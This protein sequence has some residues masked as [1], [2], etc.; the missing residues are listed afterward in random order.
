MKMKMKTNTLRLRLQITV[1]LFSMAAV[2]LVAC[3]KNEVEG[4]DETV[5]MT[6]ITVTP[7]SVDVRVGDI[8]QLTV[9]PVPADATGRP[10]EWVSS[11]PDVATV[12]ESGL[13]AALM[14][15]SATVTVRSGSLSRRIP[16]T[17][18]GIARMKIGEITCDVTTSETEELSSGVK[19]YKLSLPEFEN[20]VTNATAVAGKG[21]IINVAVADLSNQ[22][23]KLEVVSALPV[24]LTE[25]PVSVYN[26][27]KTELEAAGREPAVVVN[28]DY[29][30]LNWTA[31]AAD[32]YGYDYSRPNGIEVCNGM[33]GESPYSSTAGFYVRDNGSMGFATFAVD[34]T[35][36]AG[37]AAMS[38]SV[39]N[40]HAAQGEPVLFN[41]SAHGWATDSAFAW[42]PFQSTYV[43]LSWPDG[44]WRVNERMEFTVTAIQYGVT[45]VIPSNVNQYYAAGGKSFNG[46]GAI[47]VGNGASAIFL[48]SLS[49]GDKIGITTGVKI[50]GMKTAD[51]R[52]NAI[53]CMGAAILLNGTP[54]E[55]AEKDAH[56]RTSA[57][58]SKDG[59]KAILAVIDGRQA[60]YSTG[61]TL[62]QLGHIMKALG[63]YTA[64]NLDGGGSSAMV[65]KGEVK[66]RPSDGSA[67]SVANELM[68]TV[69]KN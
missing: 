55:D 36:D 16:V 49:V 46:E 51:R 40:G 43:S 50:N 25:S 39:V 45:T 9:A 58:C 33:V 22:D 26:R 18:E 48:S 31:T 53:G 69:K 17:V 13:V 3:G 44:G 1:I 20:G 68:I 61:V 47:L 30:R 34:G 10:F 64:V 15:G 19:W 14:Q 41:N 6:D 67:R 66:N 4:G 7:A 65:V 63:A 24:N 37:H 56:P 28:G 32:P 27:K 5:D 12:S 38:F 21:L 52:L 54:N 2:L 59:K 8:L 29:Y 35:V 62:P 23:N 57:G 42:S 60:G 11:D